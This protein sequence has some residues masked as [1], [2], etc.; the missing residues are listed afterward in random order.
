VKQALREIGLGLAIMGVF[1]APGLIISAIIW[2]V[3]S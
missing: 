3:V 1:C 2:A